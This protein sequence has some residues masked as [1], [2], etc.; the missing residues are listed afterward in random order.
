MPATP[1]PPYAIWPLLSITYTVGTTAAWYACATVRPL[2]TSTVTR[3]LVLTRLAEVLR[4]DAPDVVELFRSFGRTP[5]GGAGRVDERAAQALAMGAI[6]YVTVPQ[7]DQA[8]DLEQEDVDLTAEV[9]EEV[10]A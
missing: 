8:R 10:L 1:T 5:L 2:S 3:D 6:P 4:V 9:G 7:A